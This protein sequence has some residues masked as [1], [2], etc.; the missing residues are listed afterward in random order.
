MKLF[1]DDERQPKDVTWVQYESVGGIEGFEVIRD[2]ETFVDFMQKVKAGN[3]PKVVSFDHDLQLEYGSEDEVPECIVDFADYHEI[4][5]RWEVTGKTML[6][7]MIDRLLDLFDAA[8][9]D[10]D[11]I[12]G[13]QVY[14]HTQNPIG[15]KNMEA[16]WNG[17]VTWL[18]N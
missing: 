17:F 2:A 14:F 15:R 11:D 6:E 12:E 8:E 4:S 13:I 16:L 5:N 18:D 1:I 7:F 3:L 10:A 9:I